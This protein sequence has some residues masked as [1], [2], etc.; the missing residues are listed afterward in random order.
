MDGELQ[1]ANPT[2][3]NAAELPSRRRNKTVKRG[4]E[5]RFDDILSMK[6]VAKAW[7]PPKGF[8]P[9]PVDEDDEDDLTEEPIDEQEIYGISLLWASSPGHAAAMLRPSQTSYQG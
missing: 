6:N 4:P 7:R 3:L 9:W 1:N 2:V 5:Y 8:S